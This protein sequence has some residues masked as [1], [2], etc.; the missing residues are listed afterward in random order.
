MTILAVYQQTFN[1]SGAS[2]YAWSFQ[3]RYINKTKAG[4][5]F[6]I[7][8]SQFNKVDSTPTVP[9][10]ASLF[11]LLAITLSSPELSVNNSTQVINSGTVSNNNKII[12]LTQTQ[13]TV[14]ICND[15]LTGPINIAYE[16]LSGG[17]ITSGS[18]TFILTFTIYEFDGEIP[19]EIIGA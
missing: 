4:S 18:V 10:A 5:R 11:T 8:I 19:S 13:P 6:A 16:Y 17:T 15:F 2:T 14:Y 3:P 1:A 9:T 12:L 7:K